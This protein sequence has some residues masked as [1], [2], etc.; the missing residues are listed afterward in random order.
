M[1]AMVTVPCSSEGAGLVGAGSAPF[2]TARSKA[3]SASKTVKAT[4]FT[5]SP[6]IATSMAAGCSS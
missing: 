4:S 3:F 1:P 6:Y 2:L 5:P